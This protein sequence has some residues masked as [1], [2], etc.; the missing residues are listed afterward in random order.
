MIKE[1][2]VVFKT[3]LDI[4]FTDYSENVIQKY[5]NNFIPSAIQTGYELKNSETPFIW[6]VG[7]WLVWE[8]LKHDSDKKLEQ[9]IRDG[10][11]SWHGLP[12]TS[13][14]ELMS[15]KLFNYGLSLSEKLDRRFGKK[16]IGAKMT[17]VPGH[18]IGMVPL[19]AKKGIKF[20][21]LGVNPA[22][23]NPEVPDVFKWKCDDSEIIVMYENDYGCTKEFDDFAICFG[24]THDNDGAQ[25]VNEIKELYARLQN[26]YP[27]AV[28]KAATLNDVAEKMLTLKDLPSIYNEIGDTWIHGAA[29]DPKKLGMY[30]ELL[31]VIEDKSLDE[32][33]LS[34]NLL[35]VPEHTWGMCLQKY[36]DNTNLWYNRDFQSTEGTPQRTAFEKSWTEQ[37]NYVKKAEKLL[38][39]CA[40]YTPQVPDL[41]GYTETEIPET[42]FEF[43]WQLFDTSDYKRYMEKY[44][45]LTPENIGWAIWDYLKL[46]LPTYKGG[47]Y[48]AVPTACYKKDDTLLF[49]LEFDS[50]L[51]EEYGLPYAWL[52]T[53][54]KHYELSWF[55]KQPSRLPQA[56]WFKFK[57]LDENWQISKMNKWIDPEKIIGSPLIMA[58]DNGVKNNDVHIEPL[59]SALIAPFGR[60]LLDFE[61]YPHNQDLYFN[62]YN[63][64]WN[65]NF[66]M[67]Y[68]DDTR[69]RF[70]KH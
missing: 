28:I 23:P 27:N 56:F 32:I 70:I 15:E 21:H 41:C 2:L 22:T 62:L 50:S 30:R 49:K 37:R 18:T 13:H 48:S 69:F 31:R 17:D 40:D 52:K 24:H 55:S 34:D 54:G 53:D 4:G 67:W 29:T 39:V 65:T 5:I 45:T 14:T 3:H 59:D 35:L 19:M 63:N 61:M 43:S 46:G 33:D 8:G 42:D 51:A 11:I 20:L 36:F 25:S 68:S 1:V 58:T 60:R 10:V 12:F 44:L 9:A 38:N 57:G 26:Q 7:S 47:I 16:T 64:I 6:T 66:P